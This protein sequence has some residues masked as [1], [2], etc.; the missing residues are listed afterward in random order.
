MTKNSILESKVLVWILSMTI[1]LGCDVDKGK[2][3]DSKITSDE[4]GLANTVF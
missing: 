2:S 1:L 3:T 4:K